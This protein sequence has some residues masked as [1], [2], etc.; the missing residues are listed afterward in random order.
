MAEIY[1]VFREFEK[2][3]KLLYPIL[4]NSHS[5]NLSIKDNK[6]LIIT[7]TG[8]MS[9][10]IEI[11][12]LVK[13]PIIGLTTSDK[14]ASSE[15]PLHRAVYKYTN[16][17]AIVHTHPPALIALSLLQNSF[18]PIDEEGKFYNKEG[19]KVVSAIDSI[20]SEEIAQKISEELKTSQGVLLKG[21]G[22][23]AGGNT[24]EEAAKLISSSEHSANIYLKFLQFKMVL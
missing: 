13:L 21:H 12:S 4:N 8:T 24:L 7:K 9:S 2:I 5:G 10:N 20:G 14:L 15:L 22:M 17:K 18:T 1:E 16:W 3:G 11:D 6:N 19:L 23:F